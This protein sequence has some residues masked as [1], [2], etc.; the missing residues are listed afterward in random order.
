M[1]STTSTEEHVL[2]R[3]REREGARVELN[4]YLLRNYLEKKKKICAKKILTFVS[5]ALMHISLDADL[6]NPYMLI[7]G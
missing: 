6:S 4:L 2:E 3:E 7:Y 1:R 5:L